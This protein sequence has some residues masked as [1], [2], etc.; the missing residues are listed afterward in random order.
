MPSY[1]HPG[2]Y[3]EEIPSGSKPIEGASTSVAAFIGEPPR[4]PVNQ[5][6]LIHSWENY[7]DQFGGIYSESDTMGFAVQSFYLNGGNNAYIARI[8]KSTTA[9]LDINAVKASVGRVLKFSAS[10]PGAWGSDLYIK[11]TAGDKTTEFSLAVGHRESGVF[12]EDELLSKLNMIDTSA[13]FVLKRINGVS[14]LITV[15]IM[16]KALGNS[17]PNAYLKGSLNPCWYSKS[18]DCRK[19][20][21][22]DFAKGSLF[23]QTIDGRINQIGKQRNQYHHQQRVGRLHL[24]RQY[25]ITPNQTIHVSRLQYPTRTRLIKQSPKDCDKRIDHTQARQHFQALSTEHLAHKGHAAGRDMGKMPPTR[26]KY[27]CRQ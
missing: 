15:E 24:R 3:V 8:S 9:T 21:N 17:A 27:Q 7:V 5:A 16:D 14:R 20:A 26:S 6:V 22:H 4:D 12:K 10:S 18:Q 2:V 19:H 25:F 1:L 11:I 23:K 13:D